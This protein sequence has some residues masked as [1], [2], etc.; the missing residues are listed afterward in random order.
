[1]NRLIRQGLTSS[2]DQDRIGDS[3]ERL[4]SFRNR[5]SRYYIV[6]HAEKEIEALQQQQARQLPSRQP[7]DGAHQASLTMRHE[8]TAVE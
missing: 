8:L 6:R 3:I 7:F 4:E 2:H 1:M 5:H